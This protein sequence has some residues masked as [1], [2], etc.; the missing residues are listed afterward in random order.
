MNILKEFWYIVRLL[1]R[2]RLKIEHA[3]TKQT[4]FKKEWNWQCHKGWLTLV[5]LIEAVLLFNILKWKQNFR[6]IKL[7]LDLENWHQKLKNLFSHN[8]QS[9]GLTR[10]QQ[11]CKNCPDKT[12]QVGQYWTDWQYLTRF[13]KIWQGLT[14][15]DK[16]CQDLRYLTRCD[17]IWQD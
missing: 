2:E 8:P 3:L 10:Y 11:D 5:L 15:F 14:R 1:E 6:K 13:V 7:I 4:M 17:T 12:V 9:R 16:I